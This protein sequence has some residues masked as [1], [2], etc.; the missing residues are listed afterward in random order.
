MVEKE[1]AI[2]RVQRRPGGSFQV[3]IPKRE[4]AN[5]LGLKGGEIV[6]ILLD[7]EKRRWVYELLD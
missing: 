2:K 3:T 1:V 6:K 7:A 5:P 4:V